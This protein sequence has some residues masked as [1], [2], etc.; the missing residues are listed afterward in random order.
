MD[1]FM[2]STDERKKMRELLKLQLNS[3]TGFINDPIKINI[4][5]Y[6]EI[7]A[8]SMK[9][10][11]ENGIYESF[12]SEDNVDLNK[13]SDVEIARRFLDGRSMWHSSYFDEKY[14]YLYEYAGM[15]NYK[16][17]REWVENARYGGH[18]WESVVG[19]IYPVPIENST[20]FYLYVIGEYHSRPAGQCRSFI[21]LAEKNY[22]VKME[23]TPRIKKTI[24]KRYLPKTFWD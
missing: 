6:C 20:M 24:T 8:I 4:E 19:N 5:K 15:K 17:F 10:N 11:Y 13:M 18:P 1:L 2:L 21:A 16:K 22:P 14:S 3:E 12:F 7:V 9:A 23:I